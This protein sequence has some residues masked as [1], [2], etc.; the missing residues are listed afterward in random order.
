MKT[1]IATLL[2]I[3]FGLFIATN[4]FST[5]PFPASEVAVSVSKYIA[6]EIDYPEFAVKEKIECTVVVGLII[7]DDGTFTV[8][9]ANCI[10][11]RMRKHVIAAI[12]KLDKKAEYYSRFAGLK[13]NLKLKFDLKLVS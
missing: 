5:V 10:D 13:V 7:Q 9:A 12:H 11:D 2:V 8:N 4:A 6:D 1:R 3:V